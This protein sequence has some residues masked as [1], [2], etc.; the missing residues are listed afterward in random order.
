MNLVMIIYSSRD[1]GKK[2]M[3]GVVIYELQIFNAFYTDLYYDI[4]LLRHDG[5]NAIDHARFLVPL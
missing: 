5:L 4:L 2:R 1:A 3:V